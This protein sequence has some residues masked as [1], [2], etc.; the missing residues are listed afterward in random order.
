MLAAIASTAGSSSAKGMSD[1]FTVQLQAVSAFPSGLPWHL[2]SHSQAIEGMEEK[3]AYDRVME[4]NE[5]KKKKLGC[6]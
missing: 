2:A 3:K 4:S 5:R 6:F 1:A